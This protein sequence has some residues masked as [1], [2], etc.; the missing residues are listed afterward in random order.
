MGF[1][2]RELLPGV[3]HIEDALGVCFTL[4]AGR[5][6]ALLV[7]AGYGVEDAAAFVRG[8]T[9]LPVTL[10][11][12]HGHHDHALGA[13]RFAAARL[14]PADAA[15]YSEYTGEKWRRR[16]LLAARD[17]GLKLDEAA[18]LALPAPAP[19]LIEGE[20]IDLG[21]LTARII[22]CPGHTPGSAVVYVPERKLL[23]T[24]DDWNPCTWLFFPEALGARDYRDNMRALLALPFENVLCP[25]SA[26]LH[27]R[28]ELEA[29]LDAL[30]DEA[31]AAAAASDTGTP[32]GV[33]TREVRVDGGMLFVFDERKQVL[34]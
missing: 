16:V 7:D 22:P 25:H 1:I 26:V 14:H 3:H 27:T 31:L 28:A 29:F 5:E 12:T 4:V 13:T 32:Y 20:E 15:V 2:D 33:R 10:W 34:R 9:E 21:G 18:L 6:R 17:R 30:S 19:T 23:L 24:G 11:L 8:I